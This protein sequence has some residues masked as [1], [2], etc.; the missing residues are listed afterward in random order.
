MK[1][2]TNRTFYY[3]KQ[4]YLGH[5]EIDREADREA[6]REVDRTKATITMKRMIT[7]LNR[8]IRKETSIAF[9]NSRYDNQ[10]NYNQQGGKRQNRNKNNRRGYG[11][12]QKRNRSY[13]CLLK[14]ISVIMDR[15]LREA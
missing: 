4:Y 1:D 14:C 8:R 10:S 3:V 5:L 12:Y 13:V 15:I 6:D 2:L 7:L 11:H 9:R